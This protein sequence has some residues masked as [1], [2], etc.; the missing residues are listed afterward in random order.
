MLLAKVLCLQAASMQLESNATVASLRAKACAAPVLGVHFGMEHL[1][2]G[3]DCPDAP[4]SL[5]APRAPLWEPPIPN[6]SASPYEHDRDGGGHELVRPGRSPLPTSL[7]LSVSGSNWHY[8]G[9]RHHLPV[10]HSPDHLGK[11]NPG[12][13]RSSNSGEHL[14]RCCQKHAAELLVVY[15]W[16]LLELGFGIAF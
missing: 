15:S 7:R 13:A 6:D 8:T 2:T 1:H 3:G 5:Q 4:D 9:R 11:T 10:C 16:L 12:D 14:W